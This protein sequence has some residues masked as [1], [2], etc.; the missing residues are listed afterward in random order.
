MCLYI[1]F[2]KTD[3]IYLCSGQLHLSN[4]SN[5]TENVSLVLAVILCIYNYKSISLLKCFK[6]NFLSIKIN[7]KFSIGIDKFTHTRYSL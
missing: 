3:N 5:P 4:R 7:I 2:L 6:V 1:E